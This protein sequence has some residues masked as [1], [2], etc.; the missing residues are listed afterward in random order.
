MKFLILFLLTSV[1][2]LAQPANSSVT[3]NTGSLVVSPPLL[4]FTSPKALANATD[5]LGLVTLQQL[6]AATNISGGTNFIA[7]ASGTGTNTTFVQSATNTALTR[8]H[9]DGSSA[10]SDFQI[11][12]G[13]WN[14]INYGLPVPVFQPTATGK[15]MAVDIISSSWDQRAWLDILAPMGGTAFN[16]TN[17]SWLENMIDPVNKYAQVTVVNNASISNTVTDLYIGNSGMLPAGYHVGIGEWTA[18]IRPTNSIANRITTDKQWGY[19]TYSTGIKMVA[20]ND[21]NTATIPYKEESS[22]YVWNFEQGNVTDPGTGFRMRPATGVN[23]T[24][25]NVSGSGLLTATDDSGGLI[26]LRTRSTNFM[27]N[28]STNAVSPTYFTQIRP[29]T[30]FN[31]GI[32]SSNS[33]IITAAINDAGTSYVPQIN[34]ASSQ[35][36]SVDQYGTSILPFQFRS[37][38]NINL[39]IDSVG[40]AARFASFNDAAGAIPL[41]VQTSGFNVTSDNAVSYGLVFTNNTL[42]ARSTSSATLIPVARHLVVSASVIFPAMSALTP[43]NAVSGTVTVTGAVFGDA[44]ILN[45]PNINSGNTIVTARVTS[46]DTVTMY[47]APFIAQAT[48]STNTFI[49]QVIS[50]N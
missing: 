48:P 45:L 16:G 15:S 49:I 11:S 23:L 30:N 44:V 20:H 12:Q 29:A 28:Y 13:W 26:G 35:I 17:G 8:F 9:L 43:T 7:T 36:W 32:G 14:A 38:T 31:F 41:L 50:Q 46:S 27:V 42:S 18:S 47:A 6:Q 19:S 24:F 37:A 21:A 40:T 10:N 5:P 3:Y 1:M 22:S 4:R 34:R 2:A 33:S 39:A 25:A